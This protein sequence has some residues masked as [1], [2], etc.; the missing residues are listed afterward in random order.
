[1]WDIT[2]CFRV[3]IKKTQLSKLKRLNLNA[4]F[5]SNIPTKKTANEK[6]SDWLEIICQ[7]I[8]CVTHHKNKATKHQWLNVWSVWPRT[9]INWRKHLC[10]SHSSNYN[11]TDSCCSSQAHGVVVCRWYNDIC[12]YHIQKCAC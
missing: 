4:Q 1:M 3:Q 9:E 7:G 12:I 6:N 2:K 8:Q 10:H 5:R 11:A